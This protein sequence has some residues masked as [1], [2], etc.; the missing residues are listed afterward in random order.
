MVEDE[1]LLENCSYLVKEMF[2]DRCYTLFSSIV[3]DGYKGLCI[4]RTHPLEMKRSFKVDLPVIWLTNQKNEKYPTAEN[5]EEL[6]SSIVNF[7]KKNKK[8]III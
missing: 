4:T 1:K 2:P 8:S 3:D 6:E 7:I 5:I